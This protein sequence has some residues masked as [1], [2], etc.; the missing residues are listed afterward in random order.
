MACLVRGWRDLG[1]Y[2]CAQFRQESDG[3]LTIDDCR[4]GECVKAA[5][6]TSHAG[7]TMP[8]EDFCC[9]YMQVQKRIDHHVRF[10]IRRRIVHRVR[11][12]LV[13][14]TVQYRLKRGIVFDQDQTGH[15][16]LTDIREA[17]QHSEIF[18]VLPASSLDRLVNASHR[19]SIAHDNLLF[20]QGDE[21]QTF[22]LVLSGRLRLVQHAADGKDVT[23][24]TFGPG[25]AIALVVSV[26]GE[27]YPGSAEA[28]DD[29]EVLAMPGDL[30][31]KLMN[32]SAALAVK[33]LRMVATHL[34]EAHNRIRELSAERVQQRVARSLL[35]I[36][37][38]VGVRDAGGVIRLDIRLSRQDLAQL[39][40]T[41]LETVSRTL[42][43]WE[44]KGIIEAGREHIVIVKP[45]Q[46][47]VIAE[48]L[49]Q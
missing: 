8:E 40:G 34:H 33:V 39:N 11:L 2:A 20:H 41:T 1:V 5:Q 43:Q 29:C 16:V 4:F 22:F 12:S 14:T 6:G 23:M 26:I 44:S 48:D 32:E 10:D 45:H 3:V 28:L 31:W 46:L 25:E 42:S 27:P 18:A 19:R 30:M 47:V 13:C 9:L 7:H 17:L 15:C 35:R 37:E 49:P 24:A 21:A 38:K 36:A